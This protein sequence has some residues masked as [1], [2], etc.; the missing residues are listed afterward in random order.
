LILIGNKGV[1]VI[2]YSVMS[3][4]PDVRVQN[5]FFY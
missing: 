3:F 4:L 5:F 1:V 2:S